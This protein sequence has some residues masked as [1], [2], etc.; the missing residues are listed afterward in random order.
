MGED[1]NED[2]GGN[3][4]MKGEVKVEV[5]VEIRV[6]RWV[7]VFVKVWGG[8]RRDFWGIVSRDVQIYEFVCNILSSGFSGGQ[9]DGWVVQ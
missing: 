7:K 2:G 3:L 6:K 5:K 4:K 1:E 9:V 8:V